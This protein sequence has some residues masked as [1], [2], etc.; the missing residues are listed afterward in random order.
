MPEFVAQDLQLQYTL[1]QNFKF[2][3]F[4][5]LGVERVVVKK[6]YCRSLISQVKGTGESVMIHGSACIPLIYPPL[7][8]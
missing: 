4:A 1:F 2:L 5:I 8:Q 7:T 6:G 3:L